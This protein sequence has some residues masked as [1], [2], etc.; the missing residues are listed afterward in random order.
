MRRFL[1]LSV[2]LASFGML[3]GTSGAQAQPLSQLPTLSTEAAGEQSLLQDVKY[4]YKYISYCVWRKSCGYVQRCYWKNGYRY[5]NPV[6][7]CKRYCE[8]H[9]KLRK[10]FYLP[11]LYFRYGY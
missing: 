10:I 6:Y 8:K 9:Y 11:H 5:C 4:R 3:F 7:V 2:L 1:F